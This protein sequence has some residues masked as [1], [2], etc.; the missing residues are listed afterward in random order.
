ML[1]QILMSLFNNGLLHSPSSVTGL[2]WCYIVILHAEC[3]FYKICV[4]PPSL[5]HIK[6]SL[7]Y[8]VL[9]W[10]EQ[11]YLPYSWVRRKEEKFTYSFC[12]EGLSPRGLML[13]FTPPDRLWKWV[14]WSSMPSTLWACKIHFIF[15]LFTY[16]LFIY[17]WERVHEVRR[18]RGRGRERISSRAPPPPPSMKPVVGLDLTTLRSRLSLNQE[19][20][21]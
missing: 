17:F 6:H 7:T 3:A 15:I 11:V 12:S 18:G 8:Q 14:L 9:L 10:I 1:A 2:Y 21:A 4:L 20:D 19:S 16:L 13:L 5:L